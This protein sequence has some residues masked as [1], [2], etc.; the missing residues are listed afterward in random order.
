MNAVF[1]YKDARGLMHKYF[2][3][4]H[5]LGFYHTIILTF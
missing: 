4:I 3:N 2:T 1:F 5:L